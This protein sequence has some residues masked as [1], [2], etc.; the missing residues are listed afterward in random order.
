M[1]PNS[2]L[3]PHVPTV[4][5]TG[6]TAPLEAD[7]E[8]GADD[9]ERRPG[10]GASRERRWLAHR[11]VWGVLCGLFCV[12]LGGYFFIVLF[13]SYLL[14]ERH[15]GPGWTLGCATAA[16]ELAA[17]AGVWAGR[18][19]SDR[20][21]RTGIGLTT[22]RKIPLVGGLLCG[23]PSVL[24]AVAP[25]SWAAVALLTANYGGLS[26]AAASAAA[27][28]AD[29]AP[30]HR[31]AADLAGM[32]GRVANVAMLSSPLLFVIFK[33]ITTS[34]V[35]ALVFTSTLAVFG[36]VSYGVLVGRVRPLPLS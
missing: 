33:G 2:M 26:F 36:A 14:E 17:V 31:H 10:S 8:E 15:V 27:L 20:L 30:S 16:P 34:F 29:L 9:A 18:R 3:G 11:N 21:L 13:P 24:A 23:V 1:Q 6:E 12:R 35:P 5:R 28:A 32:N 7:G 4:Q 25:N 19:C 22:A